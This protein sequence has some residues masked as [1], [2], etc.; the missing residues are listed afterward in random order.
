MSKEEKKNPFTLIFYK[1]GWS[2]N[3]VNLNNKKYWDWERKYNGFVP[4][5]G[6][7]TNKLK[8]SKNNKL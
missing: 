1:E 3:R 6:G 4:P 8:M 7:L 5:N 2:Q